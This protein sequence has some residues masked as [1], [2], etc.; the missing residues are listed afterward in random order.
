MERWL[1]VGLGNP[2]SEYARNRHNVGFMFADHL[3]RVCGGGNF[4]FQRAVQGYRATTN[5]GRVP[6]LLL[7]PDTYMNLSGH[8]V[9]GACS[10]FKILSEHTVICYDDVD[11]PFGTFRIRDK[12]SAGGHRGLAS[13]IEQVGPEVVRIRFGIRPAAGRR[14]NLVG[15]VLSDFHPDELTAL[16]ECF[17]QSRGALQLI[18]AG[19]MD[20]AM[21]K[22]NKRAAPAPPEADGDQGGKE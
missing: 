19:R 3:L 21:N 20:R 10:Y 9:Q 12:G 16:A 22:F 4:T 15:F 17:D 11:I 14:G 8:A 18:V 2:G 7:K 1:V 5:L 13:I 6:I